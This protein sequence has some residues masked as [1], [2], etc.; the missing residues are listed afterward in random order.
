[1]GKNIQHDII[2]RAT[3]LTKRYHDLSVV[4]GVSFAV[5]RGECFGLVGPNGAGKTTTMKMVSCVSP[6]TSGELF[7]QDYD[8]N[9][10]QRAIKAML[11]VVSQ[12]DSLDSGLSVIQNLL[13]HGR[14]YDIPRTEAVPRARQTLEM[15]QLQDK[16]N[17]N[18]DYLSG[19]M[20]RRLLIGRALLHR[21]KIIILDEPT[22]GLDPQSRHM[23][24]E[25]LLNLKSRGITILLTTHF[26]EEAAYLCDRL[27]IMD[28]GQFLA[29]GSPASLVNT[30]VGEEVIELRV[31]PDRKA[32]LLGKLEGVNLRIENWGD[33]VF[34]Y[35]TKDSLD[36]CVEHIAAEGIIR[37]Y[38]NLEDVFLLL[39]G[40]GLRE[41]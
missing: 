31:S 11:G 1:M 3:N 33:S 27:A 34:L 21:P 22:T 18:P 37:R 19:G 40:R 2:I 17:V 12:S 36:E 6:T 5:S 4:K 9:R 13:A 14:Y 35:G 20:R 24:W 15:F 16:A 23:V 10:D 7:V 38:G 41:V 25:H 8:V 30:Y 39:T 26:M 29:E 32:G 28:D